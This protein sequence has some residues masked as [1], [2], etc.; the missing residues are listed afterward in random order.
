MIIEHNDPDF[1]LNM[2]SG[3]FNTESGNNSNG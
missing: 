1:E 2:R 3:K